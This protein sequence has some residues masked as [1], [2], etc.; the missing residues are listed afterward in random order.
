[1]TGTSS[2]RRTVLLV[3]N[4]RLDEDAGR[5]EKFE[6]RARLLRGRGW[7]LRIGYVE[8]TVGGLPGGIARCVRL[9][10]DADVIN[11][12]SNP[13]HLHV[14]GAVAAKVTGTPWVVEFRDPLVAN[15]DVDPESAAG[16]IRRRLERFTVTN[17]DRVVWY[18]GIQIPDD[19]FAREYPDVPPDRYRQLPPIGFEKEKFESRA[20]ASFDR[21]T[22]TYAGSFYEGWIEPYTFLEGLGRYVDSGA[23][24]ALRARFYGDWNEAYQRAAIE[25]GVD[26]LVRPESF[27]PHEE[28]VRVMKGSDALLYVGGDD[29]RN[30]LNLPTKL[31]DYIG[32]R[33]PIVA[34]VDPEFRV[35]EVIRTNGLGIV[36][37]PGDAEGVRDAIDRI[38]SGE[39]EYAPDESVF[40]RFT[41]ERSN[42]AYVETLEAAVGDGD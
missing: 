3:S 23:D 15:P 12:V 29:E 18:D 22:I 20:A 31:Y 28:I 5:A 33:R 34:I 24:A 9:A 42:E 8:P 6:A 37:A 10:R 1:M 14:A 36:V 26:D 32:A 2:P 19:Y 13:P 21:F 17:A 16:R 40:D 4:R 27:V 30:A 7:N 38:R 35:A 11:S 25:N 41:R 39:F